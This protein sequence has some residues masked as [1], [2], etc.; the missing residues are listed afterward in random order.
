MWDW[1]EFALNVTSATEVERASAQLRSWEV[2]WCP[3]MGLHS[4]TY[5][6]K[7]VVG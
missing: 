6:G 7:L 3:G 5:M 4:S 1:D 2:V